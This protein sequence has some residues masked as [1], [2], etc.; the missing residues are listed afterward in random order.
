MQIICFG[1]ND[2]HMLGDGWYGVERSPEGILYRSSAPAAEFFTPN[3]EQVSI[4]LIA[5]A[6][7][8]HAGEALKGS[9]KGQDNSG[10]EFILETNGWTVIKGSAIPG[11]ARTLRLNVENPWSPDRLYHNGDAR[12]LGLL[13]SAIRMA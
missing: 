1:Y 5:S 9:I 12:A 7:P 2:L 6:R 13:V 3:P 11:K 10:F 8:E 4:S